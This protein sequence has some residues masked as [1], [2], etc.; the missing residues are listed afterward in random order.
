MPAI[1]C[2]HR[3]YLS[4]NVIR[5]PLFIIK[6]QKVLHHMSAYKDNSENISEPGIRRLA[7]NK[8]AQAGCTQT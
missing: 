8:T 1:M 6:N 5:H 2:A 4:M 3:S 7:S